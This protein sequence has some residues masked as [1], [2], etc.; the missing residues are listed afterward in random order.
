MN[1]CICLSVQRLAESP[2]E[3]RAEAIIAAINDHLADL[4]RV[5]TQSKALSRHVRYRITPSNHRTSKASQIDSIDLAEAQRLF[6]RFGHD[7]PDGP[8]AFWT[9]AANDHVH[10]HLRRRLAT[11]AV[12]IRSRINMESVARPELVQILN[13]QQDAQDVRNAGRKY[14]KIARKLGG[15]GAL[16]WLP[17]SMAPSTY[18]Y[19]LKMPVPLYPVV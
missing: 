9:V 15:F 13:G 17:S 3:H 1:P 5:L 2:D 8:E 19:L 4:H 7:G 6:V 18:V 14:V 11:V 12:Y 16:A 10:P